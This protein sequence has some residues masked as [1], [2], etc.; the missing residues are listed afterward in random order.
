MS[1]KLKKRVVAQKIY[2][3][4]T[5]K[6]KD[7]VHT[8]WQ[9]PADAASYAQ[10]VEQI[11]KALWDCAACGQTMQDDAVIAL[12]AIGIKDAKL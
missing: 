4:A 5:G 10:M 9:L 1:T 2:H 12:A 6:L 11:C 3:N 8:G 7:T